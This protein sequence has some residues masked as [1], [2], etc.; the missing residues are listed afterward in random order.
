MPVRPPV[1]APR[2][3][4]PTSSDAQRAAI[5]TVVAFPSNGDE[6]EDHSA[7]KSTP[8][9]PILPV[10]GLPGQTQVQGHTRTRS[11]FGRNRPEVPQLGKKPEP[12]QQS[13]FKPT[14]QPAPSAAAAASR[15]AATKVPSA[16]KSDATAKLTTSTKASVAITSKASHKA[17]V[18]SK[19]AGFVPKKTGLVKPVTKKPAPVSK[20][21]WGAGSRKAESTKTDAKS[22]PMRSRP[23]S[24]I[25]TPSEK[26]PTPDVPATEDIPQLPISSPEVDIG[27]SPAAD[28]KAEVTVEAIDTPAVEAEIQVPVEEVQEAGSEDDQ[29]QL[30]QTQDVVD[31][32]SNNVQIQVAAATPRPTT[33]T[34]VMTERALW[35]AKQLE[36][37]PISSLL[38][39]IEQGFLFTP[40][41]PLSPPA[42]YLHMGRDTTNLSKPFMLDYNRKLGPEG[43]DS[44]SAGQFMFGVSGGEREN[45][46]L[47]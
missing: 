31:P 21:T 42:G 18:P 20:P 24:R 28:E 36:K 9:A 2:P 33:P 39:S 5:P 47:I 35:E 26:A 19:N 27:A 14:R 25:A 17:T 16:A 8:A 12:K 7:I 41:S 40:S 6:G 44:E 37:T 23:A 10:R 13:S 30:E 3:A 34:P 15:V 45:V 43:K 1:R 29:P 4:P 46:A 32:S 11:L 22:G 38:S